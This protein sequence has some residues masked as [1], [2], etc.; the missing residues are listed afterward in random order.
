M[1]ESR[2]GEASPAS[3]AD[4]ARKFFSAALHAALLFAAAVAALV[5]VEGRFVLL[6]ARV[7]RGVRVFFAAFGRAGATETL[8]IGTLVLPLRDVR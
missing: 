2:V 4:G 5:G 8:V 1:Y 3:F 7:P 6:T